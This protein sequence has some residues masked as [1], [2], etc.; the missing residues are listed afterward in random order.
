M[1][2]MPRDPVTSG[3]LKDLVFDALFGGEDPDYDIV[4]GLVNAYISLCEREANENDKELELISDGPSHARDYAAEKLYYKYA[5]AGYKS[6]V[7]EVR[8][9]ED[10]DL[11]ESVTW[12]DLP[13]G[14]S[15]TPQLL[16][17]VA[18]AF[19]VRD[20]LQAKAMARYFAEN[21]SA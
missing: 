9:C 10:G 5:I 18:Y 8:D 12:Y 15:W 2:S 21:R 4:S 19:G 3:A 17:E 14:L 11:H 16:A 13:V 1:A 6:S 7:P 20:G